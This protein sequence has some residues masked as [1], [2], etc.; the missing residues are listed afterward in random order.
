VLEDRA[1]YSPVFLSLPESASAAGR[2]PLGAH[3]QVA[4][5]E[6]EPETRDAA[7][8]AGRVRSIAGSIGDGYT[9]NARK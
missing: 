1:R 8:N 6:R 7:K 4:F 3:R 5:V 9:G 2:R